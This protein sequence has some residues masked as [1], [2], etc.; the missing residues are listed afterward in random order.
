MIGWNIF[1]SF[2]W[3]ILVSWMVGLTI[4][5]IPNRKAS[6]VSV[7][8]LLLGEFL[9][10]F[11]IGGLWISLD[12]PPL[13]TL[14]ETRL[15]YSFLLPLAGLL[16]FWRW[17]FKWL[18][19]YSVGLSLLFLVL[20]YIRPDMHDKS[21][22][23]A[24][25]SIWFVPHVVV[26][27]IGYALLGACTLTAA[28]GLLKRKSDGVFLITNQLVTIG[29]VFLSA[30]LVFGALWA[31]EAWGHY[32]TWD[33]KETWAF[34]TWLVYLIY[35]HLIV[36][37]PIVSKSKSETFAFGFLAVAFV[38]LMLCWFGV[39]YLPA[40]QTSVHVYS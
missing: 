21:L 7:A 31:K 8:F 30:G 40:A 27:L 6:G 2:F 33:P 10:L 14:G 25:Q 24:L 4:A 9:L 37:K 1:G 17:R 32:W 22:M 35:I 38:L 36:G 13:K 3:A 23:P 12:R 28:H 15:W 20:N 39:N 19:F 34:I 26:Y 29:F 16:V 18:N 11:F 5:L